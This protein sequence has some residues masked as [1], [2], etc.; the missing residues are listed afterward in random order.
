M[1]APGP[2]ALKPPR[3]FL[4]TR[5]THWPA[6]VL[7]ALWLPVFASEGYWSSGIFFAL[8]WFALAS[9]LIRSSREIAREFVDHLEVI[10]PDD[11]DA[12]ATLAETLPRDLRSNHFLFFSLP[13]MI[14]IVALVVISDIFPEGLPTVLAALTLGWIFLY[15]GK[16]FW[17][18]CVALRSV[19]RMTHLRVCID[20][21][22]ADGRGGFTIADDFLHKVGWY[23]FSGGLLLPMAFEF[24][25][26]TDNPA[27]QLLVAAFLLAFFATGTIA[28]VAGKILISGAYESARRQAMR[29]SACHMR[30]LIA[31]GAGKEAIAREAQLQA[32]LEKLS[33]PRLDRYRFFGLLPQIFTAALPLASYGD[34]ELWTF[35]T[36]VFAILGRG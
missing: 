22:Y 2:A 19:F 6:L 32:G 14:G 11:S 8:V 15:A 35:A 4:E 31:E 27:G 9:H 34:E 24:G 23:F 5:D 3:E 17:G 18:V 7:L 1:Q 12:L 29:E 25:R 20:P 10:C 28:I 16:G 13:F 26:G 36:E 21:F 30:A 33:K